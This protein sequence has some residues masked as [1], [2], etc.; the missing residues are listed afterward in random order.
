MFKKI[1]IATVVCATSATTLHAQARPTA[2]RPASLQV[3][4]GW[5]NANTDYLPQRVNG[6]TLYVDYDFY[7]HLGVEGE[8]RY[9]K[10][11][12][13]NIY[14]KTYEIGPRY[15]RTYH[16]RYSP[17]VKALYGRG[18]FN[19]TYRGQTLANLAYN[20]MAVGGGLD[21]TLVRHINLRGEYEYQHWFGFPDHGL[22]PSMVTIGAAY[23]F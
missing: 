11:G 18:V 2:T 7:H 23:R 16:E 12:Q 21:Y 1:L 17:Y 19:F 8:F 22:T 15:S 4:V 5:S 9:L 3:G 14:E 20:M 13:S 10:D 6:T